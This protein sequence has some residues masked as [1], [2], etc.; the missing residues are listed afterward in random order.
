MNVELQKEIRQLLKN[1]Q[2]IEAVKR[3]R[4]ETGEGLAEARSA[5]ES[6]EQGGLVSDGHRVTGP[7][8]TDDVISLLGR[9]EK[10]QA[11]KL[12]R[13][14]TGTSLK[15]AKAA[16][17]GIAE[18][19]GMPSTSGGGCLGIIIVVISITSGFMACMQ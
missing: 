5:V 8:I 4:E 2:K 9:G 18:K 14:E 1:G 3:Y 12:Y 13:N 11:V 19:N 15:E 7:D 6:L 10:I 17:E 16:V